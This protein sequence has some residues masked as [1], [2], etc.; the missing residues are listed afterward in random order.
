MQPIILLGVA[1]AA[2]AIVGTGFLAGNQPWNQFEIWVQQLG[3]AT[4]TIESPISHATVDLEIKKVLVETGPGAPFYDNFISDC[5][6]HSNENIPA[7]LG[8]GARDGLI[9]CKILGGEG[10]AIAEG[11]I[12]IPAATGYTASGT[13][14]GSVL[15]IPI[16]QCALT[17]P[18]TPAGGSTPNCLDVMAPV[19]GVK[20]VVEAPI[21]QGMN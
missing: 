3:W 1:V 16:D 4:N 14:P 20:L 7:A 13:P 11:R 17:D 19:H 12:A 15:L 9:I 21:G 2:V 10:Q 5:S 6:F 18:P 8:P